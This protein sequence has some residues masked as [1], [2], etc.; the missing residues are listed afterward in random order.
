M[1]P[2]SRKTFWPE[3]ISSCVNKTEPVSSTTLPGMGGPTYPYVF[4]VTKIKIEKHTM[5][6]TNAPYRQNFEMFWG[7]DES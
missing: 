4:T 3:I 2:Y 1:R 6:I 5:K 7:W